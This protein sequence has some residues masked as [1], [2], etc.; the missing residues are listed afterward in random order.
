MAAVTLW[1]GKENISACSVYL[2]LLQK[3][4]LKF[5]LYYLNTGLKRVEPG[6]THLP[7]EM[8]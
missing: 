3:T 6:S 5:L 1:S 4:Y 8:A 7:G 2:T